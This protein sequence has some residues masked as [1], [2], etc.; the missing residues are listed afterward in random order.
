MKAKK[1]DEE[2]QVKQLAKV[3]EKEELMMMKDQKVQQTG[4]FKMKYE[5]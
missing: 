1:L 5:E 2:D 3:K 4:E